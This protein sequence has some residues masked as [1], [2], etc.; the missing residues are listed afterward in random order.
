MTGREVEDFEQHV[1]LVLTILKT[2]DK[3]VVDSFKQSFST[4]VD[5]EYAKDVVIAAL[6]YLSEVDP[7]Q[8]TWALHNY[9]SELYLELRRQ[10]V[11]CAA[12]KLIQQGLVPGRDFSSIPVGGLAIYQ[13]SRPIFTQGNSPFMTFLFEEILYTFVRL[14]FV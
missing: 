6:Y 8:F 14:S 1:D 12:R 7:E 2:Q 9:D 3:L 11:V 13:E 4:L 10:A 5:S